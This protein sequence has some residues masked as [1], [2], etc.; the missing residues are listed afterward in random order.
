MK[1]IYLLLGTNLGDR[2]KN[3]ATARNLLEEQKIAIKALSAVYE[4]DA[5]GIE[6]QPG[7]L[8]QVLKVATDLSAKELL[9]TILG[10]ELEMGRV[11]IQKWGERL[12][13]IDILYYQDQVIDTDE[14][15][16][17]HPE[18]QN[19]RFTLVPLVELAAEEVDPVSGNTQQELLAVC[20]DRLEVRMPSL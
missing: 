4:T 20:P 18:I 7:F 3:L 1:G 13:D 8:N 16:V 2:A 6:E 11:R 14:L 19:R 5:W 10:V 17:P 15:K 9:K 12:I